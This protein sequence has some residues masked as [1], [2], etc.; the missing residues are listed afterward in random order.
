M[1]EVQLSQVR[2][3]GKGI[4]YERKTGECFMGTGVDCHRCLRI[5]KGN[6]ILGYTGAV[7]GLVDVVDYCPEYYR[8]D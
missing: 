3:Q 1:H 2:E 4:F 7:S 8:Y 6:G 5:R